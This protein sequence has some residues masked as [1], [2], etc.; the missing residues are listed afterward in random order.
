M[1]HTLAMKTFETKKCTT[2]LMHF[3]IDISNVGP[4]LAEVQTF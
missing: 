4:K 2:K 3:S 1:L